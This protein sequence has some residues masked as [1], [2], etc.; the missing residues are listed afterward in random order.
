MITQAII[1]LVFMIFN[2]VEMNSKIHDFSKEGI[3]PFLYMT[4]PFVGTLIGAICWGFYYN[5][6]PCRQEPGYTFS[7]SFYLGMGGWISGFFS[8]LPRVIYTLIKSL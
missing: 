2:L 5:Y 4:P 8:S 7:L 6:F 1:S 3:F